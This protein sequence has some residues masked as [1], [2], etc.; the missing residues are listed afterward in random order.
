MSYN[1]VTDFLALLRQDGSNVELARVPGL[2][3]VVAALARAGLCTVSTG[4]TAPVVNQPST[5]W[6]QPAQPSWT[7]EGRVFL[8]NSLTGAYELATPA[9][10]TALL[11]LSLGGY[12]FQS[13]PDA[14][15]AVNAAT[16]LLAVTRAAPATTLLRLPTVLS[17]GGRSLQIVD[18]STAVTN[19]VITLTPAA[20]DTIMRRGSWQTLSTVDQLAGMTLYPATDLNGWVIAP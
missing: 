4:Q 2:D 16:S 10:W 14:S 11:T 3:F 8:W 5:V 17:R 12:L 20:G 13:A 6:F 1:P 9:L 18:W 15:N 7:A 19:H